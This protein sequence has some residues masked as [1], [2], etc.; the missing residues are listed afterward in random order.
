MLVVVVDLECP[1]EPALAG[2]DRGFRLDQDQRDA[3]DEQHQVGPLLGGSSS[4]GVLRG[5][6]VVVLLGVGKVDQA[7]GDVFAVLAKRHRPLTG[8]P[9]SELLVGLD[10]AVA[11]HAQQDGAELVEDV[12][13]PVRLGR[14]LR[15]QADQRLTQMNLHQHFVGL[16]REVLRG[17]EMPA[18]TGDLAG[19]A[20][21][22]G[23]DGSVVGDAA[24]EPIAK[25]GF[26]GVGFIEYS[27]TA[28]AW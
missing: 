15:V 7:D 22:A 10:Q 18:Q 1:I 6:D 14:D 24:T 19:A 23:A 27:L 4:E 16:V 17:E 5:D 20:C 11:A 28:P 26:D 3:V 12:V 2:A 25:E 13:G 8:E 21:Q 9:G